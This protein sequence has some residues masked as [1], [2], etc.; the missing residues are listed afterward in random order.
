MDAQPDRVGV[1]SDIHANA[2]AFEAV[3]ADMPSVDA[4]VCAGDLVGYGPS[5]GSCLETIRSNSIPTVRGNHDQAVANGW[6]YESGD[7]YARDTL[8]DEQLEWLQQRPLQRTLFD[9]RVKLVHDTPTDPGS[10]EYTRNFTS[11]LLGDEDFLIVGHTHIQDAETFP[12][13]VV[14]NPGSVG[15][16]RDNDPKAAYAVIDLIDQAVTLHRVA[17]D[18]ATVQHRIKL[19]G[20]SDR[21]ARRLKRGR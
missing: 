18:I 19:A 1:V 17:Y 12:D 14:L 11:D 15:Q 13:G 5:P 9:G 4:L 8:A 7:E 16:P 20:I 3:R 10:W 2:V 21:N 6:G